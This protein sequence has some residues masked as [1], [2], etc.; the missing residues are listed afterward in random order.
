[1][2]LPTPASPFEW[3]Q[4]LGRPA[5]VCRPLETIAAHLFTTRHWPLGSGDG[6]DVPRN[7]DEAARWRDVSDALD[8]DPDRLARVRQVHGADVAVWADGRDLRQDADIIMTSERASALAIRV[9]DC[10]PL[11]LADPRT[12]AVAAAHA[13]WRGLAA[14]VPEVT[15][16]ALAR[17]YGCRA[18]DLMAA[19]GPAIGP[20]CYEVGADVRDRFA[21]AGFDEGILARWFSATPVPAAGNPSMPAVVGQR[22]D[23]HWFFD[24]PGAARDQLLSAGLAADRIFLAGLCTA[25]HPGAFCSYRRDGVGA[26]RLV[27]AI[28][29]SLRQSPQ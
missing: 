28:R 17:E 8:I 11:L 15:V 5:L 23:S 13:G 9:A 14:R 12:G 2:I 26:G 16:A 25:S 19:A 1:M 24:G 21:Q 4:R 27:G 6:P 10:V 29:S 18:G 3:V 7:R 22:R 20:C